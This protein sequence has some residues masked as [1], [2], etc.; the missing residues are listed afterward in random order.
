LNQAGDL[1]DMSEAPFVEKPVA[2]EA[3][4][5]QSKTARQR[6]SAALAE[7]NPAAGKTDRDGDGPRRK[8]RA[9][10]AD[11]APAVG[12]WKSGDVLPG[13]RA[14]SIAGKALEISAEID[15]AGT[16]GVIVS[17]G[18]AARG[19][20]VYL[21]QGKPAFAVREKGELTTIVA[22]EPL[23][24]G[25]FLLQAILR[26][27]GAL[28]LVVDGKQVA[29]GKVSGL[30]EEQPRGPLSVGNAPRAAVGNYRAPNPF[31]GKVS[32]VRV[33]TSEAH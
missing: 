9:A 29:E 21:D 27:D 14:P 23:G 19:Y 15:A 8:Q 22:H 33:K 11:A 7:L 31:K 5:P 1:F 17:Q 6:L 32:N 4:T 24:E 28:A 10:A 18:G 16:D 25:H 30:I 20:V 26:S 12:P 13:P 3:D 2:P